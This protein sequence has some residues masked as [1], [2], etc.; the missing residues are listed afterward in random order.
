ME[1]HDKEQDGIAASLDEEQRLVNTIKGLLASR[2]ELGRLAKE[3]DESNEKFKDAFKEVRAR[4]ERNSNRVAA[5]LQRAQDMASMHHEIRRRQMIEMSVG[6]TL[7]QDD[8]HSAFDAVE[9]Q[10]ID[11]RTPFEETSILLREAELLH[12]E[13]KKKREAGLRL[14]LARQ[15][16]YE[17]MIKVESD[18]ERAAEIPH[19]KEALRQ[20]K[21]KRVMKLRQ[22]VQSLDIN[23]KPNKEGGQVSGDNKRKAD[24][25]GEDE[26]AAKRAK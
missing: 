16:V 12:D 9:C 7:S 20:L 24:E 13:C 18:A 23:A 15:S 2:E 6:A 4:L 11:A 3:M 14:I 25:N 10:H 8:I 1:N 5:R 22:L 19:S 26:K 17:A 21:E